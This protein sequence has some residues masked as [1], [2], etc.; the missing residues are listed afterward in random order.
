MCSIGGRA[1]GNVVSRD[2][3]RSWEVRGAQ[4]ARLPY[5]AGTTLEADCQESGIKK[6]I[7][8]RSVEAENFQ[9]SAGT[10][11]KEVFRVYGWRRHA[12]QRSP[13]VVLVPGLA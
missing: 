2:I 5:P 10:L 7:E 4:I 12:N 3:H 9:R 11:L 1:A 8:E 13:K 6:Q